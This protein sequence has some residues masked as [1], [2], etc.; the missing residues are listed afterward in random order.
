MHATATVPA[1]KANATVPP[2]HEPITPSY[3]A[4]DYIALNCTKTAA[5]NRLLGNP[6]KSHE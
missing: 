1:R 4:E 5:V 6:P 3:S 2:K